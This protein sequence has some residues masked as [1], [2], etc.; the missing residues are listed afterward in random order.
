M[1]KAER[2][3]GH[4][5]VEWCALDTADERRINYTLVIGTEVQ[6][7]TTDDMVG[8]RTMEYLRQ[9][10]IENIALTNNEWFIT[11]VVE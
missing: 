4:K 9:G 3:I 11:V 6:K 2:W 7:F 5:F 8:S 10:T 1:S